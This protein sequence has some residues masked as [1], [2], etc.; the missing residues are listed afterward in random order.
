MEYLSVTQVSEKWGISGRRI[1]ILCKDNRIPGAIRIGNIW[2]IPAEAKKPLD[3]RVK[4]G[5]YIKAYNK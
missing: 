2:A 4:S 5:T 3:A 1:Q